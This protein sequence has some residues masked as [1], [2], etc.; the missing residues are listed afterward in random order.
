MRCRNLNEVYGLCLGL[1]ARVV[2]EQPNHVVKVAGDVVEEA[3]VAEEIR[4]VAKVTHANHASRC[5]RHGFR[6]V[7]ARAELQA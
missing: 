6:R 7:R 5:V 1:K 3:W 2:P 4:R